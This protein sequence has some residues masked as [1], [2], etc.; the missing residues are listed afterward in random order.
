MKWP[1]SSAT[2]FVDE[3]GL[4][5]LITLRSSDQF[6]TTIYGLKDRMRDV[7]VTR[8]IIFGEIGAAPVTNV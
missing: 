5:R 4:L 6:N 7:H 2:G 8:D 1:L 3:A